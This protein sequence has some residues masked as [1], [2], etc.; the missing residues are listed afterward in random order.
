M[1]LQEKL[2]ATQT[3]LLNVAMERNALEEQLKKV[4]TNSGESGFMYVMSL[5]NTVLYGH[6][7]YAAGFERNGAVSIK[8]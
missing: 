3:Q 4:S 5:V 1:K 6:R 7:K 2:E 8:R